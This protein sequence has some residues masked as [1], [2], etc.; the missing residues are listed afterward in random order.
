MINGLRLVSLL[1]CAAF[2]LTGCGS[3]SKTTPATPFA[4]LNGIVQ[5][6]GT[7][8]TQPLAG[9]IVTLYWASASSPLSVGQTTSDA[10]G[11]FSFKNVQPFS[12]GVYYA[13]ATTVGGVVLAAILGTSVPSFVTINEL[14]TVA[15]AYSMSRF[16]Q[17]GFVQGKNSGLQVAAGMNANLVSVATGQSSAVLLASPNADETNSLRSTRAL[18]NLVVGCVQNP[19]SACPALFAATTPP[20]GSAPTTVL[21]ALVN[22]AHYPGQQVA[23]LYAQSKLTETKQTTLYLPSLQTMP[24]A[25]TLTVKVND[26]GSSAFPFGG[27]GN[28]VFDANGYAWITNNVVQGTT[29]STTA[30]VIVLGPDGR[31]SAGT[32]GEPVSPLTT[33]GLLGPGYGIG[34]ATNG[35]VWVGNF[36]WGGVN[37]TSTGNGSVSQFTSSG[38]PLS[39]ANG[40]QGGPVMAQGT[41][42]DNTGNI[43]IASY[44][45]NQVF[46]FPQGDTTRAISYQL[47]SGSNPFHIAF[48]S[49]QTAWV[50]LFGSSSTPSGLAH[51][52]LTGSALSLI[53]QTVVGSGIK[54]ISIDSLGNIWAASGGDSKIYVLSPSGAVLGGFSG[55]GV[56]GPWGVSVDGND[57]AWVANFGPLQAGT[58]YTT[59]NMSELA[60]ANPA[61]RPVGLNLGDPISPATGFTVPSAG[62][63]VLLHS[64]TPLYGPNAPP[65]FN[66]LMRMTAVHFDGAGNAWAANNWKPDFNVD[67]VLNP[68]GDGMVIFIGIAEPPR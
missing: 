30:G 65:N 45:T 1:M 50:S 23:G 41:I 8:A 34:I 51:F 33:G 14:T 10:T 47:P 5:S 60:G 6:G 19:S 67:L 64:G 57:N 11:A 26:S 40:Y 4:S 31:P 44:G 28:F 21:Q 17:N 58:N 37:P 13:T 48:A 59:A 66:P 39:P 54:G 68:G 16:F 15:A 7:S 55:G 53:S 32:N 35:S 62:S 42:S 43:W 29:G 49:D 56:N 24:D 36:G 52:K 27:A 9:A 20:S 18:A 2:A 63:Q 25:W 12:G 38:Q 61:T 3:H 22:L 46:V